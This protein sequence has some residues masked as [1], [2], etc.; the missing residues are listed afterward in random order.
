MAFSDSALVVTT[1]TDKKLFYHSFTSAQI[2][3][4]VVVARQNGFCLAHTL[5]PFATRASDIGQISKVEMNSLKIKAFSY[6]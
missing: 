4:P 2:T 1:L 5:S 3:E 6:L